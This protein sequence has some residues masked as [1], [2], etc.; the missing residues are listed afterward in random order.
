VLA[1]AFGGIAGPLEEGAT[2]EQAG[3]RIGAGEPDQRFEY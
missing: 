2:I 1:H 3:E